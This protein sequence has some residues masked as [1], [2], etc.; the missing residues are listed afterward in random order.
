VSLK[1]FKVSFI[2][3]VLSLLSIVLAFIPVLSL[4]IRI[5]AFVQ[6][7]F[8]FERSSIFSLYQVIS[9]FAFFTLGGSSIF[10]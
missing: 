8:F 1:E 9:S 5:R 3:H 10:H 7:G 6:I 4:N 2:P